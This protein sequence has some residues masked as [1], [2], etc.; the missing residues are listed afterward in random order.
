MTIT[1]TPENFQGDGREILAAQWPNGLE[2]TREQMTAALD[3]GVDVAWIAWSLPIAAPTLSRDVRDDVL[4]AV[5]PHDE[6]RLAE[7]A[8]LDREMSAALTSLY[9]SNGVDEGTDWDG[10]APIRSAWVNAMA[11]AERAYNMA[12]IDILADL[13]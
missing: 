7:Q 5:I 6:A 9:E 12:I 13:R 8:R 11:A 2:L 10:E 1:I 4:D 3:A